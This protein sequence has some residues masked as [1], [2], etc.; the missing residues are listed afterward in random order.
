MLRTPLGLRYVAFLLASNGLLGLGVASCGATQREPGTL[1]EP[2]SALPPAPLPEASPLVQ[3]TTADCDKDGFAAPLDCNDL[4]PAIGPEAY[5]FVGDGVDNDCDGKIDNPVTTCETT[6]ASAPGSPTDFARAA[7]LCPQPGKTGSGTYDPL[8]RAEWG[9]VKGL[10]PGQ[11]LWT[12][13]TKMQQVNIVTSFG[14]N[15]P[16]LGKT[17]FGLATGPWGAADPRNSPALDEAGFRINDGCA[18]IPLNAKDCLSLSFGSPAGGIGVQ[19]W[20]ELKLWVKVPRNAN[21]MVFDYAF[22]S[23]EFNQFWHASL[24][25]AFFVLVNGAKHDG[26][27]VAKESN[28]LGMSVN[29][30]FF[31][32]CTKAPGPPGLSLD[33]SAALSDC[34]GVD[35]DA[36]KNAFGSL[37]GTGYDGAG[38]P[39]GDGTA[40]STD[41]TKLYIYGGGSGWLTAKFAVTPGESMTVRILIHD[42]FDGLKDSSV[43]VDNIRF[44]AAVTD[45]GV[46]RPR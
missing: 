25:D 38:S 43:L 44:E 4:D 5:D 40:K 28:G 10:G 33:K 46:F 39:P 29:S 31:Q 2:D 3:C 1:D 16:R 15:K 35:G 30:S 42:T 23:T 21:A 45:G 14:D 34:L 6:P 11:R 27:N 24:N 26:D 17:M 20:A 22:F 19:D 8:I 41:G 18:A 32:I 36:S 37:K 12:S 9:S 13:E 7:D